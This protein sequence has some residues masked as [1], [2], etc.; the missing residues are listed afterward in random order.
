[1]R[2][3]LAGLILAA[4]AL[5]AARAD[6]AHAAADVHV[7]LIDCSLH[8]GQ[9]DIIYIENKGDTTQDLTG[10]ELRSDGP[11]EQ[12]SLTPAGSI[13]PGAQIFVTAGSHAVNLP[14]EQ[15]Y[16]WS[17][18]EIL[19]DSGDPPD[20]VRLLDAAG[21]EV[22]NMDCNHNPLSAAT[23][24]PTLAPAA[25]AAQSN[26]T[27][28]TTPV[29]SASS[30]PVARSSGSPIAVPAGGGPPDAGSNGALLRLIAG[31]SL[32]IAGA[33]MALA[34]TRGKQALRGEAPRERVS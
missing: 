13:A 30:R 26:P 3:F 22:S 4:T 33:G 31:A 2:L 1:M 25:P 14:D 23:P 18:N 17:N 12:M 10:W 7:L 20:Y 32:A 8:P 9:L 5:L 29:R 34:A 21:N 19:R 15:V 16:L 27:S 24:V 6:G 28:S 11:G